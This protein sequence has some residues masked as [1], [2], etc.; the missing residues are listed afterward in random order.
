VLLIVWVGPCGSRWTG[1]GFLRRG[2]FDSRHIP[3]TSAAPG[4]YRGWRG[5]NLAGC[6]AVPLCMAVAAIRMSSPLNAGP[7]ANT[8]GGVDLSWV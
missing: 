3:S 7:L 8:L 5:L 2:T 4:L 6:V 1:D